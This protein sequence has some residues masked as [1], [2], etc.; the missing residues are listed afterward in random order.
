[1][2]E[3]RKRPTDLSSLINRKP[4]QREGLTGLSKET[5]DEGLSNRYSP[6]TRDLRL[7]SGA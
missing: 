1:M 3:H 2:G 7:G 5:A 6:S 4:R